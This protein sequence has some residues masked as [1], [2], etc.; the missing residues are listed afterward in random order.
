MTRVALKGP[1]DLP[2]SLAPL[3]RS[4]DDGIDRWD[5]TILVRALCDRVGNPIPFAATVAGTFDA[6]ALEVTSSVPFGSQ[7]QATFL[8]PP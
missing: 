6:P 8:S 4:G 7:L 2:T 3:G 1:I 5:G